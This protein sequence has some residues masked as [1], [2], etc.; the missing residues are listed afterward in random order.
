LSDSG[1]S[2]PSS[3][4]LQTPPATI[5]FG[6]P[7]YKLADHRYGREE[8]LALYTPISSIVPDLSDTSI[9]LSKPLGPLSLEPM[10]EEEQVYQQFS[11]LRSKELTCLKLECVQRWWE[12]S[13]CLQEVVCWVSI[14]YVEL[15]E[16]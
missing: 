16:A 4:V 9:M 14:M 1:T 3:G 10:S 11:L 8:M 7:Q 6:M 15:S 12:V 5:S 2:A 13:V